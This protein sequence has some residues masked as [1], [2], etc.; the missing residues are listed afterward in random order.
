MFARRLRLTPPQPYF[1]KDLARKLRSAKERPKS[2][3][4]SPGCLHRRRR[5]GLFRS[6]ARNRIREWGGWAELCVCVCVGAHTREHI[7]VLCIARRSYKRRA[8]S[9][10]CA[11]LWSRDTYNFPGRRYTLILRATRVVM[12][13]PVPDAA[14]AAVAEAVAAA[15]FA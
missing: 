5:W 12:R 4:F 11:R 8:I 6:L 13:G 2:L 15:A 3:P 14:A 10:Y 9:R 7:A 1:L